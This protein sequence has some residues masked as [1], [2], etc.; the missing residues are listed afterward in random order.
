MMDRKLSTRIKQANIEYHSSM[1]STYNIEQPHYQAENTNRVEKIIS[2]LA[3][4]TD[5]GNLLDI[6]CGTGFV[7]D[8]AK[9]YF[10][11]VVGIDLTQAMLDEIN[12]AENVTVYI[13]DSEDMQFDDESFDVCTAYS[14]LHHLPDFEPTVNEVFRIL[15]FGGYFY[16]DADPNCFCFS[17]LEKTSTDNSEISECLGS[18]IEA[19]QDVFSILAK[20]YNISEETVVMAE[21]RDLSKGGIDPYELIELF[22]STGFKSAVAHLVWFLGQGHI[23]HS[24]SSETAFAIDD[25]LQSMLPVTRNLYKYFTIIAQK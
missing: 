18:E 10:D 7:I 20:K 25:Y 14:F 22:E 6:G 12:P 5:G 11:R 15:R 24:I 2:D 9:K 21:Y 17:E 4:K 1:A 13:G 8:I 3:E 19:I 16:S 23:I